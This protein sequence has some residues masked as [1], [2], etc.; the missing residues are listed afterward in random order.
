MKKII[1]GRLVLQNW[2]EVSWVHVDKLLINTKGEK[3][4]YPQFYNYQ[5]AWNSI[6]ISIE[7]IPNELINTWIDS[8]F[9]SYQDLKNELIS[10]WYVCKD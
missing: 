2:M 4:Q 5:D 1:N 10:S 7:G 3:Y 6:I 9:I 8:I